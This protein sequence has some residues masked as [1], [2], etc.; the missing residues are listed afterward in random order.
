MMLA[1]ITVNWMAVFPEIATIL[2][3]SV[4]VG[5]LW[6]VIRAPRQ[7]MNSYANLPLDETSDSV[8]DTHRTQGE[9]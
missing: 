3:L 4:F 7:E 1:E 2:F 9:V 8:D 6:Y 5:V